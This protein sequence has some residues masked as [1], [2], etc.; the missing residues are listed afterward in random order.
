M[1][2]PPG[3]LALNYGV[4][5]PVAVILSHIVFGQSQGSSITSTEPGHGGRC[6]T[7]AHFNNQIPVL[8]V[9]ASLLHVAEYLFRLRS[10]PASCSVAN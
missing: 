4:S 10:Q 2:E 1:L 3:F 6:P 8:F 7:F 5:R 9:T